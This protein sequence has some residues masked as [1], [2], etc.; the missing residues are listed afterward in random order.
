MSTLLLEFFNLIT[1]YDERRVLVVDR[2][3]GP[4]NNN[5]PFL[6]AAVRTLLGR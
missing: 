6:I 5:I 4:T 2:S 1:D 3:G